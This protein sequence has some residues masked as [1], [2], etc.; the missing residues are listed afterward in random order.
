ME[1]YNENHDKVDETEAGVWIQSKEDY[2]QEQ[3]FVAIADID[4]E[5]PEIPTDI[6]WYSNIGAYYTDAVCI[7]NHRQR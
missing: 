3:G 4:R 2:P 6:N 7:C 1:L 5:N